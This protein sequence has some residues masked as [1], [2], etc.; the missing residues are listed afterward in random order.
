[1]GATV[2]LVR[3]CEAGRYTMSPEPPAIRAGVMACRFRQ[4]AYLTQLK[5]ILSA[6]VYVHEY[7]VR[8][9]LSECAVDWLRSSARSYPSGE[10]DPDL[11]VIDAL[12]PDLLDEGRT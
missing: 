2:R 7:P 5:T 3:Q 12:P 11:P 8:R 1:M 9:K 10:H 4:E 6:T